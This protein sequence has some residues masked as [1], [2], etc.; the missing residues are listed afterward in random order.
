MLPQ[1]RGRES[2]TRGFGIRKSGVRCNQGIPS[3]LTIHRPGD[4][5]KEA[6]PSSLGIRSP[7]ARNRQGIPNS[8]GIHS[9]AMGRLDN[10]KAGT[11]SRCPVKA[12]V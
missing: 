7:K 6:V 12:E 3:C 2:L 4:R 5:G 8:L 10:R 9:S 11:R 1:N